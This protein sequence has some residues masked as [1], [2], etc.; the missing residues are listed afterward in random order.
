MDTL[1]FAVSTFPRKPENLSELRAMALRQ[2]PMIR[3]LYPDHVV[4]FRTSE[5]YEAFDDDAKFI[6]SIS[7]L[8]LQA[9]DVAS[10]VRLVQFHP[11]AAE[12]VLYEL[13]KAGHKVALCERY[14]A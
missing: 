6:V 11:R 9:Y 3:L 13:I 5:G 10:P 14:G 12:R 8:P 4:I 1:G 7:D 2:I